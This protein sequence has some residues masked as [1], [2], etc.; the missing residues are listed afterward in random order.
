MLVHG[1]YDSWDVGIG[2]NAVG[3]A[4]LLELASIF[5]A[6]RKRLRR[7]LLVAWW[8][9]HSMGRYAGSTWF[10]DRFAMDLRERCVAALN[11]D[12]PGCWHATAYDEVMWMAEADEFCRRAIKDATGVTPHR[13]R[14]IRAGDYSFNQLGLTSFF[15]LLSNIPQAERDRLGFYPVGGCGGNTA[16]HTEDDLLSIADRDNL[17]RDLKVY[18]TAIL[19]VLNAGILPFD[20]RAT[21]KEIADA[22][23]GY[24]KQAGALADF[25]PID[26]EMRRLKSALNAFYAALPGTGAGAATARANDILRELA[27]LL[28]PINYSAGERFDHDP[29]LPLGTVPRLAA[30]AHLNNAPPERRPFVQAGLAREVNKVANA[31]HEAWRLVRRSA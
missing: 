15:M 31:L 14:P 27:R 16:W 11:I 29:A 10:A 13:L 2:D 26:R 23:D 1:H 18:V 22:V 3:D 30:A 4:T 6:H 28:V 19:R 25:G 8:P 21:L 5:H 24:R 20:Y 17:T 12:S 9:G 7:S